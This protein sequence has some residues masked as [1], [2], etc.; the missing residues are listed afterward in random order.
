MKQRHFRSILTITLIAT[1]LTAAVSAAAAGDIYVNNG[2]SII[3]N[4]DAAYAIGS[5]GTAKLSGGE[6]QVMTGSGLATLGT[7]GTENN[8]TDP[9]QKHLEVT[10]NISIRADVVRV[11][12]NYS[13]GAVETANLTNSVGNGFRFGYFDANRD[14]QELGSTTATS[15]TVAKDTNVNISGAGTL[16][17]F[18]VMLDGTYSSF[19][20]AKAA[21]AAYSGGFPAYYNGN[22]YAMVGHYQS[23]AEAESALLQLGVGGTA[24]TG[25]NRCIVVTQGGTTNILFEFDCGTTQSLAVSPVTEGQK[26][27]T[28]Y[29]TYKYYGDFQFVRNSGENMTVINFVDMEDYIKGVVSTEM[30]EGWPIEALKAQAVCARTYAARN[31][32]G[33]ASQGFDVT[34]DTYSQ[35]Y[36]GTSRVGTT[37][38]QA[39]EATA[40]QYL[41]YHGSLCDALYFSSSGGGTEDSETVFYDA[42]PYLRGVVDPYEKDA[43]GINS[44]SEWTRSWTKSSISSKIKAAGYTFYDLADINVTF[45]STGNAKAIKFT[46]IY[47]NMAEFKNSSCYTFCCY[48]SRLNLPSIHFTLEESAS[49]PDVIV[50]SGGGWGHNVGMSQF[51]AYAMAKYHA[52]TYDQILA[53]YYTGVSLS[54]GVVA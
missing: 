50:F 45:S 41:T 5:G 13:S 23:R 31:L 38:I 36:S 37:I 30:S 1:L 21:A 29:K 39:V 14:F 34:G 27:Q 32:N 43:A 53:F 11:G 33:Y 40:G 15:I 46:D 28:T 48:T 16:G 10:G 17:C 6:I 20:A 51:G 4:L 8:G 24:Y 54:R 19:G 26:A 2:Q 18:H 12:I 3:P 49:N 47:G 44:Y 7:A 25:S 52:K 9:A 35:A 22:Y 42:L